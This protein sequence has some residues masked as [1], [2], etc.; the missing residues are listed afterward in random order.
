MV[1]STCSF[2]V[3]SQII[4]FP[5]AEKAINSP[6]LSTKGVADAHILQNFILNSPQ[7][8]PD[9]IIANRTPNQRALGSIET[10]GPIAQELNITL[11]KYFLE[12]EYKQMIQA[13]LTKPRY[14]N[15]KILIC[16]DKHDIVSIASSIQAN[17][18]VQESSLNPSGYASGNL[19]LFKHS[20][21]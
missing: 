15:K 6:H 19:F 21:Q 13:V 18:H 8:K 14:K 20:E 9:I 2:A 1:S 12:S 7:L 10:C 5:H 3:P 4:I 11:Q 17:E 16:W